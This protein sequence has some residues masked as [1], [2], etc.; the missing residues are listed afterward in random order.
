MRA[1][2]H[3]VL[4]RTLG[5]LILWLTPRN[6]ATRIP[7]H[8]A[9]PSPAAR[10]A[11]FAKVE[12]ALGLIAQHDPARFRRL[13]TDVTAIV[14]WPAASFAG[15]LNAVTRICLLN[16]GVVDR[17]RAGIATAAVLVHEAMHARLVRLGF[18]DDAD[19]SPRLERACKRA[20]LHFLLR[21]PPFTRRDTA[22]ASAEA[23][24]AQALPRDDRRRRR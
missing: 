24:V 5:R 21:L 12:T 10:N 18:R 20:E 7:V 4:S 9:L 11:C 17:D 19:M 3:V 1:A 23:A 2:P 15:S 6:Q 13:E 8:A 16:R 22:I 14:V